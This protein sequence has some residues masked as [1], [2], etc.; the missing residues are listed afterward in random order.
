LGILPSDRSIRNTRCGKMGA[1]IARHGWTIVAEFVDRGVGGAKG[2]KNRLRFDAL[3][4]VVT[5]KASEVLR[6]T[7]LTLG[8][9]PSY[10]SPMTP[11]S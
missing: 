5:Q 9:R 7:R 4:N 11:P 2:R 6:W 3:L 10:Q 1:A 8:S